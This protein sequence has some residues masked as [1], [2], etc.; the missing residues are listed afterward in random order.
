MSL[1]TSAATNFF[2]LL[3]DYFYENTFSPAA[4]KL[5]IKNLFPG[6][7]IE[8]AFGDGDDDL[9]THELAFHVRVG[10]VFTGAVVMILRRRRVRREF[11][12]PDV[13]IMQQP[14]FGVVDI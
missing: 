13:I 8:F 1:V 10:I 6:A 14:I 4:I 11:L 3:A 7:E 12:Q 2:E 5:S 9:T